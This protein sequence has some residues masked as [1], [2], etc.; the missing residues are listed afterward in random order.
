MEALTK[1]GVN[2]FKARPRQHAAAHSSTAR[3]SAAPHTSLLLAMTRPRLQPACH[4]TPACPL[5]R[6]ALQFFMAYKGALQVSDSEL[7][8]GMKACRRLGALVQVS[9]QRALQ[10]ALGRASSSARAAPQAHVSLQSAHATEA[11]TLL[12][13]GSP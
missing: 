12:A 1:Q 3:S 11:V 9:W 4:V 13:W 7:L 6:C 8:E 2:S 10:D 5:L